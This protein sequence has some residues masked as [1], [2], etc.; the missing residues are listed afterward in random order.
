MSFRVTCTCILVSLWA[1]NTDTS[2]S[3]IKVPRQQEVALIVICDGYLGV[4]LSHILSSMIES[5]EVSSTPASP[6]LL[7]VVG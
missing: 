4:V 2:K 7:E 3:G 1:K 6:L 5:M